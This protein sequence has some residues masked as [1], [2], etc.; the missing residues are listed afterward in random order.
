MPA[1]SI[2]GPGFWTVDLGLSRLVSLGGPQT[3]EF[4][5]E[6]FNL[7]NNFNWG[8]P[9]TRFDSA[10]VRSNHDEW[11]APSASCS[12]QSSMRSRAIGLRVIGGALITGAS[13]GMPVRV[14][15]CV[16]DVPEWA[17]RG[18]GK[19]SASQNNGD[20]GLDMRCRHR[21]VVHPHDG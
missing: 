13:M 15:E 19:K 16:I 11:P 1:D 21:C 3:M 8:N 5:V 20:V 7:L 14:Q 17:P 2:Q 12:S 4:R 10:T 18:F 9:K 6:A